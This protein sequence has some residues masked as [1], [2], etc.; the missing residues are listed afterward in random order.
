MELHHYPQDTGCLTAQFIVSQP[1]SYQGE[2]AP[3]LT[4]NEVG[5]IP[6]VPA[7]RDF[8]RGDAALSMRSAADSSSA[9]PANL[10]QPWERLLQSCLSE[11][12]PHMGYQSWR[13][14]L[15]GRVPG[16]NPEV[17]LGR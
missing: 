14:H 13:R 1:L 9:S 17:V 15:F 8:T 7:M 10:A 11:F 16:C 12:N 3:L 4:E 5:S 2:G 6:T